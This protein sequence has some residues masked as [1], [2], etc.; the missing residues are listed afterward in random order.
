M[1]KLVGIRTPRE[2]RRAHGDREGPPEVHGS[3]LSALEYLLEGHETMPEDRGLFLGET[4]RLHPAI[5]SYTSDLFYEGKLRSHA[6]LDAQV[7]AGPTRFAGAGLFHIAVEHEGNQN[8]P[9][10][11]RMGLHCALERVG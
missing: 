1:L 8:G 5:C 9:S 6:G 2:R 10:G 11:N 7:L 4:W 3:E